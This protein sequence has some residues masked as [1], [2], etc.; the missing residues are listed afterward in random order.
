MDRTEHLDLLISEREGRLVDVRSNGR[1]A[2]RPAQNSDQPNNNVHGQAGR[3]ISSRELQ[4]KGTKLPV[5]H[6]KLCRTWSYGN[7]CEFEH[8]KK[9][10]K[11]AHH[12]PTRLAALEQ[13]AQGTMTQ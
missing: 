2:P 4:N 7:D 5:F 9:G 1:A 13:R 6:A 12:L 11:Y 10:C 3:N 8:T